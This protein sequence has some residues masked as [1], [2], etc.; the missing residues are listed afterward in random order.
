M[1]SAGRTLR[2]KY[3]IEAPLKVGGTARVYRA[4]VLP[5][6]ISV[7]V[8]EMS[9]AVVD[10]AERARMEERFINEVKVL[11]KL[12]H[13][14]LPSILDSFR[15]GGCHYL[16]MELIEGTDLQDRLDSG[17]GPIEPEVA[18]AW[19]LQILDIL[20][21]LH[22]LDPP[23]IFRDLKPSNV[24]LTSGGR[25][26]LID[27]GLAKIFEPQMPGTR[28]FLKGSG[29][30]PF[31]P[32]EQYGASESWTDARSDLYALGVTIYYL[33]TKS[34][35]PEPP[36]IIIAKGE[37]PKP[38]D[39][40]P[41]IDVDLERVI[42]KAM[43]LMREARY[44]SA[45]QMREALMKVSAPPLEPKG[46]AKVG[47]AEGEVAFELPPGLVILLRD[48][49]LR[50]CM[51]CL[52]FTD[53]KDPVCSQCGY[54]VYIAP[55][56]PEP[57]SRSDA[58]PPETQA[59]PPRAPASLT[60][61]SPPREVAHYTAG[62]SNFIDGSPGSGS[63]ILEESREPR[64]SPFLE[65]LEDESSG[66]MSGDNDSLEYGFSLHATERSVIVGSAGAHDA[67]ATSIDKP[68]FIE[69]S[70]GPMVLV[71]AG[72]FWAGSPKKRPGR[73]SPFREVRLGDFYIDQFPVTNAH[74]ARFVDATGYIT[75]AE[76]AG[77]P[78]T[79][80]KW[81]PSWAGD[82]PVVCVTWHDALAWCKWAGKR[83]PM[84][85]EW[86]KAAR[87]YD[88][89]I[90]PW[91]DEEDPDL[92]NCGHSPPDLPFLAM[93]AERGTTPVDYFV[94]GAS[95]YEVMDLCGNVW[96][97]VIDSAQEEYAPGGAD[98]LRLLKGGCWDT[99][100]MENLQLSSRNWAPAFAACTY[101]G[102]RCAKD[103]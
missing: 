33:L 22:S 71:P 72:H 46:E 93:K 3:R 53:A 24:M 30:P 67:A 49:H 80:R 34:L 55:P 51:Q 5:R 54:E 97:W 79:W 83:L 44:E 48:K 75:Q 15:D 59:A 74:F 68:S 47:A 70:H 8:K 45:R 40:N 26:K 11:E 76:R 95:T 32:L 16:V 88:L 12:R 63:S 94:F 18:L 62:T 73:H 103:A 84:E 27:F 25:L 20:D 81:A 99:V 96:E 102:F 6:G 66:G 7:A 92:L 35:P 64:R 17:K 65:I 2:G 78:E 43:A 31:S 37:I 38:T 14:G 41:S 82:Y 52:S 28:Y 42:L 91:G 39:L 77:A 4:T 87:G 21:Y 89:R 50:L 100:G 69:D 57:P 61:V 13:P 56:S 1:L 29:T 101:W 60:Q 98:Q 58:Q 85:L 86:E 10:A 9:V 90:F 19:A 23:V 36:E